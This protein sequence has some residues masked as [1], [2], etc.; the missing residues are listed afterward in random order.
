VG[1]DHLDAFIEQDLIQRIGVVGLVSDQTLGLL[2]QKATLQSRP[3]KG[4]FVRASTLR[5]DGERR[6][7]AV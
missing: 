2:L 7:S 5:V 6:R 1:S 3:N 4:D